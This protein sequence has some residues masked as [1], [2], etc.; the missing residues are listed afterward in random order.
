MYR[1]L[2]S[3][4]RMSS[5]GWEDN[6]LEIQFKDGAVYQYYNVSYQEYLDFMSSP[7]L[8]RK[9]SELDKIHHYR[10]V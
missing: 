5:V 3:S 10:P 1:Q 8:G 9:L 7:S 6:V 2:V 4:S